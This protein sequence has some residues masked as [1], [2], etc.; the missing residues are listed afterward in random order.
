M[1]ER[2]KILIGL[3]VL[4]YCMSPSLAVGQ[5]KSSDGRLVLTIQQDGSIKAVHKEKNSKWTFPPILTPYAK[6]FQTAIVPSS[7][8]VTSCRNLFADAPN[9][10]RRSSTAAKTRS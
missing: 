7:L 3:A 5:V 6:N 4:V 10:L 2:V 9:P 8:M 1:C